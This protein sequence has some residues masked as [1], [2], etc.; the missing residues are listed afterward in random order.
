VLLRARAIECQAY[1]IAAAQTGRHNEKRESYGDSLVGAL[2][3][4][5]WALPPYPPAALLLHLC[6]VPCAALG[7][8]SGR[9]ACSR[10]RARA[11]LMHP[12]PLFTCQVIDP[13][14][15]IIA[16]FPDLGDT[17]VITAD[18][19][20]AVLERVR[21][22]MPI[23]EHRARGQRQYLGGCGGGSGG[24]SSGAAATATA[25]PR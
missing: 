15:E 17:G 12:S 22:K 25:P 7:F 8:G 2:G 9:A 16:R 23:R 11:S 5:R 1:V 13:W 20:L 18:I 24:G 19:D 10:P 21:G 14:G 6:P 3:D 4:G